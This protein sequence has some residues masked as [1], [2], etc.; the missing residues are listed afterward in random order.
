MLNWLTGPQDQSV[1]VGPAQPGE[2][3]PRR[4]IGAKDGLYKYPDN[5]PEMSTIYGILTWAVKQYPELKAMGSRKLIATHEKEKIVS[6]KIDGKIQQIPR[7]WTYYELSGYNYLSY[8][9]LLNI[10][11]DYAAGLLA[12]G[13]QPKGK[14][15]FPTST[16]RLQQSGCKLLLHLMLTR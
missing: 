9:E 16:L 10:V 11:H 8:T 5:V 13:I 4:N 14:E 2:T 6:K 12:I 3:A 7:K 1:I 15:I